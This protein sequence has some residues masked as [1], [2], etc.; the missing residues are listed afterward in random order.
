MHRSNADSAPKR[1]T[2]VKKEPVG[3]PGACETFGTLTANNTGSAISYL[4]SGP[5]SVT[6]FI[7][8]S[9]GDSSAASG[10]PQQQINMPSCGGK[11]DST[12]TGGMDALDAFRKLAAILPP[13]IVCDRLVDEF[14]KL[15]SIMWIFSYSHR[16]TFDTEYKAFWRQVASPTPFPAAERVNL[17]FVSVLAYSM[18]LALWFIPEDS[19][20]LIGNGSRAD[21]ERLRDELAILGRDAIDKSDLHE[22]AS[23]SRVEALL[24]A[25]VYGK[26]AVCKINTFL[27][28]Y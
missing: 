7:G 16:P 24:M 11:S 15:N 27:F 19:Y 22:P 13:R 6:D 28:R 25:G 9:I 3:T 23:R 21:V 26:T 2:S 8:R 5:S 12:P 18:G 10:L 1:A 17:S 4:Y 20:Y 14:Y